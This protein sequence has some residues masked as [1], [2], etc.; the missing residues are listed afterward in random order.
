MSVGDDIKNAAEKMAGKV[1]E[2]VGRA[3]DDEHLE[4]EGRADQA[5][6]EAKQAADDVKDAAKD[7]ADGLKDA[8]RHA[9]D[10]FER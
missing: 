8:G 6:A 2:G 10:A 7:A 5:K 1:K 3:T 9:R 4:N